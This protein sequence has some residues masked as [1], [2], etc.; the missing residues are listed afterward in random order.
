MFVDFILQLI[1]R[2]VKLPFSYVSWQANDYS[3]VEYSLFLFF[4]INTVLYMVVFL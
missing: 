2:L 1:T 4:T 3:I